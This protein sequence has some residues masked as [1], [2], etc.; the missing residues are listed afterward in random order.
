MDAWLDMLGSASPLVLGTSLTGSLDAAWT[1]LEPRGITLVAESRGVAD[2][3]TGETRVDARGGTWR[4]T[5]DQPVAHTGRVTGTIDGRA[6]SETWGEMTLGGTLR[7][8]C[9]ELA[10]CR[11]A[12]PAFDDRAADLDGRATAVL[13]L[14]GVVEDPRVTGTLAANDFDIN[15]LRALD[16]TAQV[17]V[18][19]T[20]LLVDALDARLGGNRVG[21]GHV[22]W[23]TG[24][25]VATLRG[26]L[27]ELDAFSAFGPGGWMPQGR[28][29]V[30][31]SLGGQLTAPYVHELSA[32]GTRLV[33][34]P[35][36]AGTPEEIPLA[37]VVDVELA[38]QGS[39]ATLQGT[40]SFAGTELTWSEYT[41]GAAEGSI[42]LET[43][44][45]RAHAELPVLA[46]AVDASLA[47]TE[48][49]TLDVRASVTNADLAHIGTRTGLPL[50]GTTSLEV[51]FSRALATPGATAAELTLGRLEGLI[52]GT[53]FVLQRPTTAR[54]RDSDLGVEPLALMVGGAKVTLE[55]G[56]AREGG[57]A[58]VAGLSGSGRDLARLL[59]LAPEGDTWGSGLDVAGDVVVEARATGTLEAPVVTGTVRFE[60]GRVGLAGHPPLSDLS[61]RAAFRDGILT[62]E[63]LAAT[64]QGATIDGR[65]TLSAGLIGE[66]L[67][68]VVRTRLGS[69]PGAIAL[70]LDVGSITP[71]VLAGYVDDATLA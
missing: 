6:R 55:G 35:L 39:L 37:G 10:R 64:W 62:L 44:A 69:M 31:A 7:V 8:S 34:T 21:G 67:P 70:E 3:R 53:P 36:F 71:A 22:A 59:V 17:A 46:A 42:T 66:R 23:E 24:A 29:V 38:A 13:E 19:A 2:G 32:T 50:V 1:A 47:L 40:L 5:V 63:R 45:L 28:V 57:R 49:R 68:D 48:D 52:G 27:E 14:A 54:Y 26:D 33:L 65:G 20:G 4:L 12:F 25:M 60:Q 43:D 15:G 41:L 9:D 11:E 18:D 61:L 16:L 51:S 58:L 30:D 56:L